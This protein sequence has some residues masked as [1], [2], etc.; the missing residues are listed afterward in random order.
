MVEYEKKIKKCSESLVIQT[1]RVFP[2]D[3]NIY[4]SMFG[5]SILSIIDDAASISVSRHC[6]CAAVTASTD[7]MDFLHPIHENHSIC[8]ET[9]VSGVG[10]RS[11][12]V[13]AKVMGEV[14]MSGERYLA[15]TCFMTFVVNT[16]TFIG[17]FVMPGIRPVTNEE[18]IICAGYKKR[19]NNRLEQLKL[20]EEIAN[21]VSFVLPW[22]E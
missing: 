11:L 4:G 12:E 2:K 19:R 18:K 1:H 17:D 6:R 20:N 10:T 9:Y 14:L 3:L 15:G 22:I 8:V 16:E 13:F 21:N 7:S 5:G